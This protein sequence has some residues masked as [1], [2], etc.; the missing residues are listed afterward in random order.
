[1]SGPIHGISVVAAPVLVTSGS[2][3]G[4]GNFA[5]GGPAARGHRWRG[6]EELGLAGGPSDLHEAQRRSTTGSRYGE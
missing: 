1:M 2:V 4:V 6:R 3:P 5:R